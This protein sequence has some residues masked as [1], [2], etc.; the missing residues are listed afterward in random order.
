MNTKVRSVLKE[1]ISFHYRA[2]VRRPKRNR[3]VPVKIQSVA[4]FSASFRRLASQG[5]E[6]ITFAPILSMTGEK[7]AN[8]PPVTKLNPPSTNS[9]YVRKSKMRF[10]SCVKIKITI[11][12]TNIIIRE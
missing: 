8:T 6:W 2:E 10:G 4:W 7:E 11:S 5:L 1:K 12:V 3:K 9:A